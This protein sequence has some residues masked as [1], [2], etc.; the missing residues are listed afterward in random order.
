M[1]EELKCPRCGRRGFVGYSGYCGH[2]C[3]DMDAEEQGLKAMGLRDVFDVL[4]LWEKTTRKDFLRL[5]A[6]RAFTAL[7]EAKELL[8]EK[9]AIIFELTGG[10]IDPSSD[11]FTSSTQEYVVKSTAQ[12]NAQ[13]RRIK[14]MEGLLGVAAAALGEVVAAHDMYEAG[15]EED[16]DSHDLAELGGLRI[17]AELA[18][19]AL[20]QLQPPKEEPD[21]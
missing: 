12:R 20:V 21:A 5:R 4:D 2:L 11:E 6:R 13:G 18:R 8:D 3:S 14:E 19:P 1:N 7:R 9:D 17:A 15:V 10:G 16:G